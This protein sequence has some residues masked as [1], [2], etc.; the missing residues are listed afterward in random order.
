MREPVQCVWF[1][2]DLRVLD[3]DALAQAAE[4]GPI[5][6]VYFIEPAVIEAAD[7]DALH[8]DFIRKSLLCLQESLRRLGAELQVLRG[9]APELLERL[10]LQYD[11]ESLWAHE[12]TGNAI[13]YARDRAVRR[14]AKS[15][16]LSFHELPQNGVVR[17][18]KD[19]DG[20]SRQWE[21]FIRA[22]IAPVPASL[23]RVSGLQPCSIPEAAELGLEVPARSADL[24]GGE[25]AAQRTLMSFINER[26]QRYHREMSSPNVAYES[27][28]RLSAYL[29]WGCISM[30]SVVQTVRSAAGESMPKVAARS[31]LSR[32]HWHCHFMQ[33]LESEPAIEF[34]AFNRACDDLRDEDLNTARLKAWQAGRTGYPFIDACIRSLK[35]RG[36]INF[37]MRAMLVSFASYHLWLDWRSFKDWLACQF[38]D[39]EPGIHISQVQMQSG[40]TGINTL[41]IYNPIKQG[42]DHDPEGIFT[43]R[44]VPEL[45]DV[46][47]TDIHEPWKMPELIQ[48]ESNCLIG[49]DYP[50]PIVDH[51]EAIRYARSRFSELR[52][53]DDYWEAAR[54]VMQRHGSRKGSSSR[55]RPERPKRKT[56]NQTELPIKCEDSN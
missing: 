44:W 22:P 33:K 34:H 20:W 45:K 16:Q 51:K 14:W 39:Y 7:F 53:R 50:L 52:K 43:R 56:D 48:M 40:L 11:V 4:R 17:R 1:K 47:T 27:C 30:R 26:G 2:R 18:L 54:Q 15:N 19:R 12:E 49:K 38:I 29:A 5:I 31:F 37:R 9:D 8:W 41:R 55:N 36:W 13:T 21:A 28:S 46:P 23:K 32:C 25:L 24:V 10:R 6:P 3:N 42:Q 35:T